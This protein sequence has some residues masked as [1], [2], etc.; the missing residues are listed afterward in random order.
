MGGL[1]VLTVSFFYLCLNFSFFIYWFLMSMSSL[2]FIIFRG[3]SSFTLL[4]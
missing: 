2:L 1:M 4:G 3:S